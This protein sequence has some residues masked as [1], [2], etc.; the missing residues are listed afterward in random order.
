MTVFRAIFIKKNKNIATWLFKSLSPKKRQIN[1]FCSYLFSFIFLTVYG[2]KKNLPL[3][4]PSS[5]STSLYE[6]K[7][8]DKSITNQIFIT[9]NNILIKAV[10]TNNNLIKYEI[11]P[12]WIKNVSKSKILFQPKTNTS[13]Q[14]P[15][16]CQ[17]TQYTLRN[18]FD[19]QKEKKEVDAS[20]SQ[21]HT[22]DMTISSNFMG[23]ISIKVPSSAKFKPDDFNI[24]LQS[25]LSLSEYV[26]KKKLEKDNF[27]VFTLKKK[28]LFNISKQDNPENKLR[29]LCARFEKNTDYKEVVYYQTDPLVHGPSALLFKGEK[30][31]YFI[32]KYKNI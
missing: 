10:Y 1:L 15:F 12:F 19:S 21:N 28:D 3:Q 8:D 7:T 9:K 22:E 20:D 11:N 16:Q 6:K 23:R 14:A 18:G 29:S 25:N 26:L 32:H 31:I 2:E 17:N 30:K 5:S 27:I 13:F 4:K 24:Y